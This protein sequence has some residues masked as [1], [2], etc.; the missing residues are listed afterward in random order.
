MKPFVNTFWKVALMC[1]VVV[2]IAACQGEMFYPE[3]PDRSQ[4]VARIKAQAGIT[5]DEFCRLVDRE[6]IHKTIPLVNRYLGSLPPSLD[7]TGRAKAMVALFKSFD[8]IIDARMHQDEYMR[9][10]AVYFTFMDGP[11]ERELGINVSSTGMVLSY[12]YEV[13]TS[14]YA[15]VRQG[16]TIDRVLGMINSLDLEVYSIKYGTYASGRSPSEAELARVIK[17]L[18]AKP[19]THDGRTQWTHGYLHY[20]TGKIV[21]S[22]SLFGMHDRARQADWL[23]TMREWDLSESP[24]YGIGY[25]VEF[26]I[27]EDDTIPKNHWTGMFERFDILEVAEAY[28]KRY[29]LADETIDDGYEEGV[30]AVDSKIHIV[31]TEDYKAAPRTLQFACQTERIYGTIS[32]PIIFTK[33]QNGD[34]IDISFKGVHLSEFGFSALGPATAHIDL[35]ELDPGNYT[36]NFH[37][38]DVKQTAT[39]TVTAESYTVEMGDNPTFGFDYKR[40]SRIPKNA[41]W[42]T[43]SYM[44]DITPT[45][46]DSFLDDLLALGVKSEGFAPGYYREF[47]IDGNGDVVQPEPYTHHPRRDRNFV[48]RYD[49]DLDRIE[50]LIMQYMSGS[51][52]H[53]LSISVYTTKGEEILSWM[54]SPWE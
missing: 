42:G 4:E 7:A 22:P 26:T 14:I 10:P 43:V 45:I 23:A 48:F 41:I 9:E 36:L 17:A 25:A 6:N 31:M 49:G 47:E 44:S 54:I 20:E 1:A 8:G 39:L 13:T 15:K 2:S 29:T 50:E 5:D 32:N 37:N 35:G 21:V 34:A 52:K 16:V 46:A 38:G 3:V 51:E 19:Y 18:R 27:P 33:Q 28:G 53:N 24:E 12:W 11:T 30:T 40:L